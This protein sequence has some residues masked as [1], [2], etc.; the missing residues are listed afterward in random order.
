MKVKI[1]NQK[2]QETK[3]IDLPED[4]F[5]LEF[6]HD[7]VSQVLYIQKS[8][9]RAGTAHVKG[10]GEVKG[11]NQKPWRQKGTGRAR[12]GSRISPIWV[13]GGVAH[14]P[15]KDKVYKKD[16]PKGMRNKALFNILSA[17]LKDGKILFVDEIVSENG[18]TKE[19]VEI[20][21][22]ISGVKDFENLSYKKKGNVYLTFPKMS[23]NEKNS[24]RNLPYINAHNMEDLNPYDLANARYLVITNPEATIEYLQSKLK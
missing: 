5:G 14:G 8:N 20:V 4:I 11:A 13:G 17:K 1:Y 10:R 16:L 23:I 24:F 9:R 18:K 2:G 22:A 19:A 7:L 3:E 6:N 15:T 21:K 12:H